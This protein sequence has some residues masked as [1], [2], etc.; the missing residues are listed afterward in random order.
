VLIGYTGKAL[1]FVMLDRAD[2]DQSSWSA[3]HKVIVA[4]GSA[5][6]PAS[7]TRWAKEGL[8]G[9]NKFVPYL[10]TKIALVDPLGVDPTVITGSANFSPASTTDNDENMLVIRGDTEVADVYFTE[11]TRIFNHF[12]ARYWAAQLT[13]GPADARVHSFLAETDAWQKPYF[14]AGNPKRLQR[15]LFSSAVGGNAA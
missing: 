9:F 8:T 11:F 10:H 3:D 2:N 15:V 13:K 4:V 5:G 12:Y 14:A 7:L 6:G 1:H